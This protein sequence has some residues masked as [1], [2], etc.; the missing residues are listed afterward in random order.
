MVNDMSMISDGISESH[1]NVW[2]QIKATILQKFGKLKSCRDCVDSFYSTNHPGIKIKTMTSCK[3]LIKGVKKKSREFCD[4]YL[5][6]ECAP[7]SK[8]E[9]VNEIRSLILK[10]PDFVDYIVKDD[11]LDIYVVY[12]ICTMIWS[13]VTTIEIPLFPKI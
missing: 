2:E 3:L 6:G 1:I 5:D 9:L 4:I 13:E 7:K 12:N 8:D 10:F 11:D